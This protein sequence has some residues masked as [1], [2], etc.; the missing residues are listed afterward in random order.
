MD[1][2]LGEIRLF[3]GNFAPQDWAFCNG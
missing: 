3:G 2:F 1:P